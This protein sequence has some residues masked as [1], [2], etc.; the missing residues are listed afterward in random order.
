MKY[1]YKIKQQVVSFDILAFS[2]VLIAAVLLNYNYSNRL[3]IISD[4]DDLYFSFGMMLL[5]GKYRGAD[6]GPL[7]YTFQLLLQLLTNDAIKTFYIN[8]IITSS[9]PF[10]LFYLLLRSRGVNIWLSAIIAIMFMFSLLNYPITPKLTHYAIIYL[11]LGLLAFSYSKKNIHKVFFCCLF[12]LLAAYAR[13]ELYIGFFLLTLVTAYLSYHEGQYKYLLIIISV[14]ILSG[15]FLGTPIGERD[16]SFWTFKHH[17]SINYIQANPQLNLSPWNHFNQITTEAFGHKLVSIKDAIITSPSLVI[18]HIKLNIVNYL[19]ML[20]TYFTSII[21]ENIQFPFRKYVLILLGLLTIFRINY[22][23]TYTNLKLI[24]KENLFFL[25]IFLIILVPTYISNFFIYPRPHYILY[26]F[27]LYLFLFSLLC[28]SLSF[29]RII[30]T[31]RRWFRL[32]I[33]GFS[34]LLISLLYVPQ[35]KKSIENKPLPS[36]DFSL[37]LRACNLKGRVSVLGGD[38]PFSYN[39]FVGQNWLF[40][41]YDIIRPSHFDICINNYKINC[42]I[43]N[44]KM[45]DYFKD[46]PSYKQFIGN[47]QSMGFKMVNKTESH[48]VYA[49]SEII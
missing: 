3:D 29:K 32:T 37:M 39:R 47:P 44:D 18:W 12:V 21:F 38:A 36:K 35:Y 40:N 43:I 7:Y 31:E 11:L 2:F 30:E 16:R 14:A 19:K 34:I 13:P 23:K 27:F 26:H 49:K 41:Y 33:V 48:Q 5:E 8:Y 46:D 15:Y 9:V 6:D 1:L 10:I 17:F 22:T 42:V 25:I 4:D 45:N 20:P 24:F 28:T